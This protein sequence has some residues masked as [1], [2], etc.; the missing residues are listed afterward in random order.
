MPLDRKVYSVERFFQLSLLGLVAAGYVAVA[1]SGFLD[2]PTLVLVAA[3]LVLRASMVLGVARFEMPIRVMN[4]ITMSYIGFFALD[5]FWI[6]QRLL[7]STV[8]LVCFLAV[9]KILTAQTNR[10]YVYTAVI[11]LME[12]VA[13]AMLSN[14]LTFFIY[15]AIYLFC[16]T[17]AFMSAEMRRAIG[18][19]AAIAGSPQVGPR[20]AV[21]T[22][23]VTGGI[24]ALTVVLFVALPRTANAA[25]RRL[26][27]AGYHLT[28]FSSEVTLGQLGA[29]EKDSSP[30]MHV[31]P[32]W[33][34]AGLVNDLKWRGA[35]LSNFD[36]KR[37]ADPPNERMR[38]LPD[39]NPMTLANEEQRSRRDGIRLLYR[40]DLS[41]SDSDVLFIAGIPEF[42]N[43][44]HSR[45]SRVMKTATDGYRLA[46][47][48]AE[49]GG[50]RVRYEVSSFVPY[51]LP[52]MRASLTGLQ[53]ERYLQLP[54]LDGR[55]GETAR[56]WA[57]GAQGLE[58]A[59][60]IEKHLHT[61]FQYSLDQG[62]D[63]AKD[64]LAEFLF[65]RKKGFCEYFASAMAVMLRTLGIPARIVNGFQSGTYNP[66]SD[67]YVI[68]ASDAHS[69]V[70]AYDP[71]YG[72]VTFDPTP[73]A[74]RS[75]AYP[76]WT[77]AAMYLDAA[78]TFWQEWV[79]NY[80]LGRQVTLASKL[81]EKTRG[82]RAGWRDLDLK[83]W[84]AGARRWGPWGIG[85][86]AVGLA[87]LLWR[88]RMP[89]RRARA[90]ARARGQANREATELYEKMLRT[91]RQRGFEKP[92]WFTPGEFAMTIPESELGQCVAE[93]TRGYEAARFG[94]DE[95]AGRE[96]KGLLKRI[97][98]I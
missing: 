16:A 41:L 2:A 3:A 14:S 78:E 56:N 34:T 51:G 72:W 25:F 74:P 38:Q 58:R 86:A 83:A 45:D 89:V 70:E 82:F 1:G 90:G 97:E 64:P 92:P 75:N 66:V 9:I 50:E 5:Y 47:L 26:R 37:W 98:T 93:F 67:M 13:A 44:E 95:G 79:V 30:V 55:I 73:P 40:V 43:I 17:A 35:A 62:E 36:G 96:L 11:A 8:H 71:E 80:D 10:D 32:Y 42:L 20:L 88:R 61:D 77:K 28:G 7:E 48:T 21:L 57:G 4:I 39:V 76:L 33:R 65:V 12:L 54:A 53:R 68:R 19:K 87:L 23:F 31:K 29:I 91:V 49:T 81:E 52:A 69:W 84:L 22:V 59:Y 27:P 60:R 63:A 15:L 24:L 94:G 18:K 6:S 46:A 85:A